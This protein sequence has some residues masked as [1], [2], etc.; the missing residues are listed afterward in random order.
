MK[1][2][3]NMKKN[4]RKLSVW[5]SQQGIETAA[6]RC[7]LSH[8]PQWWMEGLSLLFKKKSSENA[9]LPHEILI[10]RQKQ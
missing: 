2:I 8:T 1:R 5:R 6:S 3:E 4:K 7:P 10:Q 9:N